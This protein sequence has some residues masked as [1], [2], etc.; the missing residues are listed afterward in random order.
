MENIQ[1]LLENGGPAM[2]LNMMNEELIDKGSFDKNELVC[3]LLRIEKVKTALTY[4]DKFNDYKS[5][6]IKQLNANLHNCYDDCFERFMPFLINLGFRK[7]ISILDEKIGIMQEVYQYLITQ[8]Y[9]SWEIVVMLMLEA[10]YYNSDMLDYLELKFINKLFKT[11]EQQCF[12]IYETDP[13][14]IRWGK[15][16]KD[17]KAGPFCKDIH[18]HDCDASEL[19]LPTIYHI[20]PLIYIYK[21][22]EDKIKNKVDTIIK[23][24]MEPEY[25]KLRG[26]YGVS[27]FYNKAYY[28][29]SPGVALP[30]YEDKEIHAG[31]KGVLEMV[32][33]V[34]FVTKTDWFKNCV[35]FLEK[36][37]TERGTYI[38]SE[39][40][41]GLRPVNTTTVS[42]Y[43]SKEAKI[44][45]ND[46]RAFVDELLSTYFVELMKSRLQRSK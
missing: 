4:F 17:W 35:D 24:I 22:I 37:K 28:A 41:G 30:F 45:R 19:P 36:Y 9:G 11:A 3:E 25:Q 29:P 21:F 33:L 18:V 8:K 27:W 7:G 13:S 23:Y 42:A 1:W 43:I 46:R 40:D 14:K 38:L 32:S 2:K 44:K 15:V 5:V 31:D 12:D 6:T 16:P 34:P 10:G 26:F 39:P 20:K